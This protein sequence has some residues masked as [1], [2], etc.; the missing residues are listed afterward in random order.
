M[1][2]EGVPQIQGPVSLGAGL[3]LC[4]I[5]F[6]THHYDLAD[7][8]RWRYQDKNRPIDFWL[9]SATCL[10]IQDRV[11]VKEGDGSNL[12]RHLDYSRRDQESVILALKLASDW[13]VYPKATFTSHLSAFPLIPLFRENYQEFADVSL[14]EQK[15]MTAK[16]LRE[17]RN[18]FKFVSPSNLGQSSEPEYVVNAFSSFSGSYRIRYEQQNVVDLVIIL[19]AMLGVDQ[20][21]LRRRLAVNSAVV[22]GKSEAERNDVFKKV[23]SAYLIRNAIVHGGRRQSRALASALQQFDPGLG[24]TT[25]DDIARSVG[26]AVLELRKIVRRILIAY[27]HMKTLDTRKGWPTAEEIENVQFNSGESRALQRQLGILRS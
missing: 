12:N 10:L 3:S 5:N 20:E 18:Y 4:P 19:E 24:I 17:I 8:L 22:I 16:K 6:K 11:I 2:I 1:A 15:P 27:I 14:S 7:L 25:A 26:T 9:N 21:E 13:Y 23:R